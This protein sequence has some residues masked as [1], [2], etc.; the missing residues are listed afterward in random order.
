MRRE[1]T[2]IDWNKQACAPL[3]CGGGGRWRRVCAFA[4]KNEGPQRRDPWGS[5]DEEEDEEEGEEEE[6]DDEEEEGDDEEGN[7]VTPINP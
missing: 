5:D 3:F 7:P 1:Y 4:F 6:G 2:P